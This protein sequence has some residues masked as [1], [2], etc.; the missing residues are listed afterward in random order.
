MSYKKLNIDQG[1][2]SAV[3]KKWSDTDANP[4]TQKKGLA[5][6]YSILKDGKNVLLIAY[7][8]AGGTTT[9]NP[10]SG[11]YPELSKEIADLIVENCLISERQNTTL[12]F[13]DISDEAFDLLIE[14]LSD[15]LE[16]S[17]SSDPVG[18][19]IQ[20]RAKGL[21]KDEISITRYNNKT[22]LIQGKPLN[23]YIETKLFL[24]EYLSIE[25]VVKKESDSYNIKISV[26]DVQKELK[27]YL[28]TAFD[29]LDEKLVK[30]I[31]PALSLIK[32]NMPLDDYSSFA[33]PVLR[34]MEGYIRQ[35]LNLK[36]KRAISNTKKLSALFQDNGELLDFVKADISCGETCNALVRTYGFY[37]SKRH[38]YF[39]I[40]NHIA[41]APLLWNK[42]DAEAI[43]SE[44][45]GLIEETYAGIKLS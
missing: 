22:T 24:Y 39:H 6:H 26:D 38:P 14:Y 10:N 28:P 35:L 18:H 19:G 15:V 42:K 37:K 5:T 12:S 11:T 44:G 33:F 2:I 34:G 43:I 40:G 36:A 29:F 23:L 4:T 45:L 9:L 25:E 21:Y 41:T 30:I 16:A 17:V 3:I 13:K 27:S 20:Y 8:N 32:L 31:T 7:F 1:K